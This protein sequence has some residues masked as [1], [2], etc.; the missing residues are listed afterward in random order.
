[1]ETNVVFFELIDKVFVSFFF[2]SVSKH[3]CSAVWCVFGHNIGNEQ[4]ETRGSGKRSVETANAAFLIPE[5]PQLSV[6]RLF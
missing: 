5:G 2:L 3:F 4:M 6:K 1:M